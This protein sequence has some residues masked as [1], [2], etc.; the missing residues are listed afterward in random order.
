MAHHGGCMESIERGWRTPLIG[1][2]PSIDSWSYPLLPLVHVA[3]LE[4]QNAGIAAGGLAG[5][6][7]VASRAGHP[8]GKEPELERGAWGL[9]GLDGGALGCLIVRGGGG[10][11]LLPEANRPRQSP[12]PNRLWF[13]KEEEGAFRIA[14]AMP[15]LDELLKDTPAL[16]FASVWGEWRRTKHY[17][18]HYSELVRL[19]ALYK[20]GG[21]YLDSDLIVL[22]PLYSLKNSICIV[23]QRDG[24]STFS[25]AVM[26]FEKHRSR[27]RPA[28]SGECGSRT[29]TSPPRK[30]KAIGSPEM[31]EASARPQRPHQSSNC[32]PRLPRRR[33]PSAMLAP[34]LTAT[35]LSPFPRWSRLR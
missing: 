15:N 1:T 13:T 34:Q 23:D 9:S 11:G 22:K 32:R 21:V 14:V 7:L 4:G 6:P 31:A 17:P 12:S 30:S 18:L 16:I 27:R 24:N 8:A 5:R 20:Y 35:P 25:G 29:T 26:A 10:G 3:V 19:A 2:C 28:D 33:A